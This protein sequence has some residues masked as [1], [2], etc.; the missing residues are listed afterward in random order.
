MFKLSSLINSPWY[1]RLIALNGL[2]ALILG[3]HLLE[4]NN[5]Y[6]LSP[7]LETQAVVLPY[8]AESL[9]ANPDGSNPETVYSF[10][11]ET[12]Y[13]SWLS[14]SKFRI[15]AD[16]CLLDITVND[17]LVD[18]S[19]FNNNQLCNLAT[20]T[21]VELAPYLKHGQNT[22]KI[23]VQDS[24]VLYSLNIKNTL[25]DKM[26]ALLVACTA[27]ALTLI[28]YRLFDGL[29]LPAPAY[30]I[31]LLALG[32]RVLYWDYTQFEDRNHDA[33]PHLDYVKMIVTAGGL[34][35]KVAAG[36]YQPTS[37]LCYHPTLYYALGALVYSAAES[38]G[39]HNP[40]I[41]LQGFA[42]VLSLIFVL[43]ALLTLH[44]L[45]P[46]RPLF[47]LAASLVALWPTGIMYS[48][49]VANDGLF[50][51]E[52]MAAVY[53]LVRWVKSEQPRYLYLAA[54][55]T[56][57]ALFT[58]SNAVLLLA[59]VGLTVVLQFG[60][61]LGFQRSAAAN[62]SRYLKTE[63]RLLAI[64]AG[65]LALSLTSLIEPASEYFKGHTLHL[66][67]GN[68]GVGG[69]IRENSLETS[70]PAFLYFDTQLFLQ[71][72]YS[73]PGWAEAETAIPSYTYHW[74]F[75]LKSAVFES[76]GL[77]WNHN[78]QNW[79]ANRAWAQLMGGLWLV[80]VIY[81]V[82]YFLLLNRSRFE[83][84]LVPSVA[85]AILLA[86]SAAYRLTAPSTL[87]SNFKYIFP[88]IVVF[89]LFHSLSTQALLKK[90][91]FILGGLGYLVGYGFCALSLSFFIRNSYLFA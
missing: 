40:V 46:Q 88:V 14:P 61:K 41:A 36:C 12:P 86:G 19:A 65:L 63:R 58:K 26:Y 29:P 39:W 79:A 80:M 52:F 38:A 15:I 62:W 33:G 42:V 47:Y 50:F 11:F 91:Y 89:V 64:T 75:L 4:L 9:P 51:A 56:V 24:G 31:V 28:G 32:I 87:A 90:G 18:L 74:N 77:V 53:C 83:T 55:I 5:L 71:E 23:D 35:D 43:F 59:L 78:T 45:L 66:L 13:N 30:F 76:F 69:I 81:A 85:F 27:L 49:A 70:P 67:S 2:I 82:G 7:G 20:G 34:P 21:V 48:V 17:Q 60:L 6:L 1:Y 44:E 57:L 37:Q 84:L 10:V 54:G 3:S 25:Q 73:N 22:L 72:S 8:R 68:W 16:N